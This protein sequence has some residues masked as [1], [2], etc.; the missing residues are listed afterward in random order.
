MSQ[1]AAND[2]ATMRIEALAKAGELLRERGGAVSATLAT[3]TAR[4]ESHPATLK[5]ADLGVSKSE[6]RHHDPSRTM[7]LAR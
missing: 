5:L 7:R 4:S 6:S 3:A 2:A 1:A